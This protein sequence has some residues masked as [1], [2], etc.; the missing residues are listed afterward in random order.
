MPGLTGKTPGNGTGTLSYSIPGAGLD[1]E[2]VYAVIDASAAAADVIAELTVTDQ[3]GVVIAKRTQGVAIPAGD[4]GSATW[5]LRLDDDGSSAG[6]PGSLLEVAYIQTTLDKPVPSAI[7]TS[8]SWTVLSATEVYMA[9]FFCGNIYNQGPGAV[10][11]HCSIDATPTSLFAVSSVVGV[12][13]Y[14]LGV[15]GWLRFTGLSAGSHSLQSFS[16]MSGAGPA[17]LKGGG[18]FANDIPPIFLAVYRVVG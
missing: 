11:I 9:H 2:S 14:Q 7:L 17:T 5:A 6:A 10:Q 16:T 18:G 13:E 4:T 1:L 12:T 15:S 8:P 3:S